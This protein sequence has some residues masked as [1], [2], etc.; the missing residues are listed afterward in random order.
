MIGLGRKAKA[1]GG[2]YA[3]SLFNRHP[4]SS[5]LNTTVDSSHVKIFIQHKKKTP[6]TAPQIIQSFLLPIAF[7]S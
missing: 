5:I 3:A 1:K 6:D 2:R 4:S 7:G